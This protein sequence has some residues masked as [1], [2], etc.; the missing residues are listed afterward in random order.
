[1]SLVFYDIETTGV[2]THFDQIL[3]FA[4]IKTD[5]FFE[6]V[7]RFEIRCRL[8][9][10]VVPSPDA[11]IVNGVR[12]SQLV[13]T[14]KPTHYEMV[15]KIVTKLQSWSPAIFA[16]WNTVKFDEEILRQA[17]YKTLHRPYLTN[18]NGNSRTDVMKMVQACSIYLPGTFKIPTGTNGKPVFKLIR[19]AAENGFIQKKAHE[20]VNDV[21]ATIFLAKMVSECASNVWSAFMRFSKKASV[22]AF[23][24]EEK[25]FCFTEYSYGTL[26]TF[27][28]TALDQRPNSP[29]WIVFD[30][31]VDPEPLQSFSDDEL[32]SKCQWP[33]SPL[34]VLKSNAAPMI[35]SMDDSPANLPALEVGR[36]ELERR[37]DFLK[38]NPALIGHLLTAHESNLK[39]FPPAQYVEAQIYDA[40]PN[41]GDHKLMDDFHSADWRKR[42]EI[43]NRFADNRLKT[44]GHRLLHIERPHLLDAPTRLAHDLEAAKRVVGQSK[45]PGGL[46]LIEAISQTDQFL[47]DE[48]HP[49]F[50]LLTE[51]REFLQTRLTTA[52]SHLIA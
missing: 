41:D 16:G 9:P 17:L 24:G 3:Q 46:T 39:E 22:I 8:L 35:F 52:K 20:A 12:A 1:M 36:D 44:L 32:A 50:D 33:H 30:L 19:V 4:A 40:F 48:N 7:D 26:N 31:A 15:R 5:A 11:M 34:H 47:A 18:T 37:A 14:S 51:H 29:E 10:H 6:E 28:V 25:L 27:V 2:D 49:H 43:V 45:H 42:A 38:N 21:Q 23:L 13:D